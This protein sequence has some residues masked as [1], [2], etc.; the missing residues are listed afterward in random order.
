M[1]DTAEIVFIILIICVALL[2]SPLIVAWLFF[3]EWRINRQMRIEGLD[4]SQAGKEEADYQNEQFQ[5]G[6]RSEREGWEE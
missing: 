2:L 1:K 4:G 3:D 6:Y 5:S